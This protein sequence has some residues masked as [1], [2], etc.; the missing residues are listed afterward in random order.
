MTK[1]PQQVAEEFIEANKEAN[2]S[3][4]ASLFS[5]DYSSHHPQNPERNFRGREQVRKNQE[6]VYAHVKIETLK[7][8]VLKITP[9]QDSVV[10][11]AAF[12]AEKKNDQSQIQELMIWSF[13]IDENGLIKKART[14]MF[15]LDETKTNEKGGIEQYLSGLLQ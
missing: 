12:S 7:V 15:S 13:D 11:E 2:A 8:N 5:E 1:S 14:Y 10:I 9:S 3:K 4:I 6:L